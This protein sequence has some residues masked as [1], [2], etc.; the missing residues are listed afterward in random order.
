MTPDS[1]PVDHVRLLAGHKADGRPV[2]EVLPATPRGPG[3]VVLAGS[4]GL[5]LG[6]AAG[7]VLRV[8]DDGGFEVVEPGA[9]LCVQAFRDERFTPESFGA[10]QEAVAALGGLAEAPPDLRFIVVTVERAAGLAAVA[11]VMDSWAAGVDDT[12]WWYGNVDDPS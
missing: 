11:R 1:Q 7:D 10:L 12:T 8:D 3:V 9:N 4:P 5:V 6:C 2:Y